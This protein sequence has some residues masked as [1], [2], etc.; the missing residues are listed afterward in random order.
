MKRISL[1]LKDSQIDALDKLSKE[2]EDPKSLIIRNAISEY[3]K[4]HSK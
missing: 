1:F 2:L 3:I 4:K